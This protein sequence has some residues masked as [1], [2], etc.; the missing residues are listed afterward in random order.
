MKK[1]VSFV[2]ILILTGCATI[3]VGTSYH[4]SWECE[5]L[6]TGDDYACKLIPDSYYYRLNT[7]LNNLL[8]VGPAKDWGYSYHPHGWGNIYP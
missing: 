3:P 7:S 2:A 4:N 6:Q 1:I 8:Y 5:K